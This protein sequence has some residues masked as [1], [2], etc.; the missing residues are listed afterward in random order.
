[1][2][3]G[4]WLSLALACT[5][6]VLATLL[7]TRESKS[8]GFVVVFTNQ[9]PISL[10]GPS[11]I[12]SSTTPTEPAPTT[13]LKAATDHPAAENPP[14]STELSTVARPYSK[15][16][17]LV[18]GNDNYSFSPALSPL[19]FAK[20][21]CLA[22]SE[23][24][25]TNYGFHVTTLLN[26]QATLAAVTNEIA[27]LAQR[28]TAVDDVVIYFVGHGITAK[29]EKQDPF[30][31][32]PYLI[33]YGARLSAT[34][35]V[36][37]LEVQA[38]KVDLIIGLLAAA[39]CR[40]RVLFMDA[41]LAG[42][43]T[44]DAKRAALPEDD[45]GNPMMEP[46]FQVMTAGTAN[47]SA[48]EL[49]SLRDGTVIN[50]G[51]FTHAL[52]EEARS[53]DS[54]S[55]LKLFMDIR[56][57][58]LDI[59]SQEFAG[60][61]CSPQH[62]VLLKRNG[63]FFLI[64]VPSQ[65]R[66]L[67]SRVQWSKASFRDD[68]IRG[69]YLEPFSI[70]EYTNMLMGAGAK[71]LAT[72]PRSRLESRAALGDSV[73]LATLTEIDGDVADPARRAR[74]AEWAQ[75]GYETREPHGIYAL[76][77]AYRHG[78]GVETNQAYADELER[79]S[80]ISPF[81]ALL[82]G[83][84]RIAQAAENLSGTYSGTNLDEAGKKLLGLSRAFKEAGEGLVKAFRLSPSARIGRIRSALAERK[85][86][87]WTQVQSQLREWQKDVDK[88]PPTS[89]VR[90]AFQEYLLAMGGAFTNRDSQGLKLV[91]DRCETALAVKTNAVTRV[92]N[93]RK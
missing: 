41:C 63:E 71:A 29:G 52:L 37:E 25:K 38:V 45:L 34:P 78:Y 16:H 30:K 59:T 5:V 32:T 70:A 24:F 8:P 64:P 13:A 9:P 54:H 21:D 27:R 66:W 65:P 42:L 89:P 93:P 69:H 10:P 35:T 20:A 48:F 72:G 36:A 14:P 31:R 43:A 44:I 60:R 50:H 68:S 57:R 75:L 11:P 53:S 3:S 81:Q 6:G 76:S 40:H 62:R 26:Q 87:A 83:G 55:I 1:M 33:P 12:N 19:R 84:A 2:I 80:G 90:T 23:V 15:V 18:I 67:A 56:E 49:G 58:M 73:A 91:L 17:A 4:K 79:L 82:R 46:S 7:L 39:P 85:G 61:L 74:A 77:R 22:V 51:L 47:E 86:P 92:K 88:M 28:T